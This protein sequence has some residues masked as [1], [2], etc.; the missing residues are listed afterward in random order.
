MNNVEKNQ[1]AHNGFSTGFDLAQS[2]YNRVIEM[3]GEGHVPSGWIL[4]LNANW[5]REGGD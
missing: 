5:V 4:Y 3:Y 2:W 1:E